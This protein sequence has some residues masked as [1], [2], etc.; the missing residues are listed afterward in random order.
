MNMEKSKKYVYFLIIL[1]VIAIVI[2]FLLNRGNSN[3]TNNRIFILKDNYLSIR[4]GEVTKIDY[5]LSDSNLIIEWTSN[6]DNF[7]V[8]NYGE[9][10]ANDYGNAIITGTVN[11]NGEVITRTCNVSSYTGDIGT[12]LTSID[13]ANGYILMKPN[14]EMDMPYTFVPDNAYITMV[15]YYEYDEDIITIKDNKIYSNNPGTTSFIVSVNNDQ[16]IDS[17]DIVVSEEAIE[18][19]IIPEIELL[20]IQ[21]ENKEV[22]SNITINVGETKKFIYG[23][24]PNNIN[25]YNVKWDSSDNKVVSINDGEIKGLSAGSAVISVMVNNRK[26][27][28]IVVN[29]KEIDANI[30]VDYKPKTL[31][32]IGGQTT[33]R[34][35]TSPDNIDIK[36]SSSNPNVAMVNNGVVTGISSGETVITLSTDTGKIQKYTINVLPNSGFI[37]GSANLWGYTSLNAKIPVRASLSFFQQLAQKGTG[38][39]QESNYIIAYLGNTYTYNINDSILKVSD[40]NIKVRFYY[41]LNTDLSLTNTVVYLGGRGE[42][43]FYGAFKDIEKNLSMLK[44][45][46]IVATL[47]E[48]GSFNGESAAY[49]TKF[50]KAITRQQSGVK[51]SILGFSDGAHQVLDAAKF[52]KYNTYVIFSGYVDYFDKIEGARNSEI[53][54]VIAANDGNYRGVKVDVSRMKNQGYKSVTVITNA[55]DLGIYHSVFLQINPLK[56][57]KYGHLTE[58]IFNSKIIEYLND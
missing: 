56:L 23:I 55:T 11:D 49:V 5:E 26:E 32:R 20:T 7:I 4:I 53:I 17:R 48:G 44:S 37:S 41:P 8:N 47:A 30:I 29:V 40:K 25:I 3:I 24:E 18:N 46:G 31:L 33:I 28:T 51:N 1:V 35:H 34:A 13:M 42:K 38:V 57:M 27:E 39:I 16:I 43:N 14:S 54:F 52:E 9:V 45:A 22:V 15:N 12:T 58:N 36:Y 10:I 50:L 19:G 6:N 2:I 21:D